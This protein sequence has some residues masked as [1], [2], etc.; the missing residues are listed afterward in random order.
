VDRNPEGADA[1]GGE[2]GGGREGGQVAKVVTGH[3][4]LPGARFGDHL[5]DGV[6]LVAGHGRAQL[7]DQLARDHLQ[8][9]AVGDL[10]GRLVDRLGPAAG[11]SDPAGVDSNRIPLVLQ[12]GTAVADGGMLPQ[13]PPGGDHGRAAR[14]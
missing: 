11:I 9:V 13:V 6:A 3:H 10:A 7:P 5:A 14:D 8:P 12:P 4:H 2:L 1:L